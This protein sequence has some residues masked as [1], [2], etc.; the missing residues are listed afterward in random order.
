[1]LPL[2]ELKSL[3]VEIVGPHIFGPKM[4]FVVDF[5]VDVF[6]FLCMLYSPFSVVSIGLIVVGCNGIKSLSEIGNWHSSM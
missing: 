2:I 1:M 3:N 4:H 5:A 6:S